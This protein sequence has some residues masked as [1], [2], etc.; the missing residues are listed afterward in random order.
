MTDD[1][2]GVDHSHLLDAMANGVYAVDHDRRITFWN[3]SAERISGYTREQTLGHLCGDGLLNHVNAE[4]RSICGSGCPLLATMV[5]GRTRTERV[6]L[7]HAAGHMVPVRVT[8]S[9]LRDADGAITGAVETF[10]DD[11]QTAAAEERLQVAERLAMTDPLTG[12]GNRRFLEHRLAER[13]A[14]MDDRGDFS[15]LMMDLDEFKYINDSAGHKAGDDALRTVAETLRH[16]VRADDDVVRLGGDEFVILTG[17]LD[18]QEL[19]DLAMRIRS[20]IRQTRHRA[21]GRPFRVTASV[22]AT[23]GHRDDTVESAAARADVAML[24]AKRSGRNTSVIWGLS[25]D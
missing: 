21:D 9:A 6:L 7:H 18:A 2:A 17:A 4:G 20:A 19:A 23:H 15:L 5:D 1:P 25:S 22:G 12:L 24:Q 13:R 10:T 8:A 16:V 3:A 14:A 11:S